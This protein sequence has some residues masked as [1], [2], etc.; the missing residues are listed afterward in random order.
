M[1]RYQRH[2]FGRFAAHGM[3]HEHTGSR[4]TAG[5]TGIIGR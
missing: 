4:N 3:W 2:G 5:L 1:K